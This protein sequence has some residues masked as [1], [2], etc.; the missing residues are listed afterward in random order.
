MKNFLFLSY[1]Y[2]IKIYRYP[3]DPS[4]KTRIYVLYHN[5]KIV[6]YFFFTY[7]SYYKNI[8]YIGTQRTQVRNDEFLYYD[9]LLIFCFHK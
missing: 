2:K 6:Y 4:K 1:I 5:F 3:R 8:K 7:H 9:E